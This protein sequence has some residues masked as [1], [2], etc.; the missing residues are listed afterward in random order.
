MKPS[1]TPKS[2]RDLCRAF[3][4][5]PGI[6]ELGAQR[7]VEW[8][9]H[10]GDLQAF[11]THI[12]AVQSLNVCSVCNR[13]ASP[14]GCLCAEHSYSSNA[15]LIVETE[16]DL[17]RLLTEYQVGDRYP[18][19]LFVL[20]GVLSPARGVGPEQLNIPNLLAM[21]DSVGDVDLILPLAGSVEGQATAEFIQRK[22]RLKGKILTMKELLAELQGTQ[23]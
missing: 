6:G 14:S 4:T 18:K 1:E 8:L 16:Q 10:H 13:L 7:L 3:D 21:L 11:S 20:H 5:L 17:A 19:R 22:S 9:V 12:A 2:Y 23:G 15:V